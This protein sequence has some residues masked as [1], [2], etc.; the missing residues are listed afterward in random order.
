MGILKSSFLRVT[1]STT[2]LVYQFCTPVAPHSF[3]PKPTIHTANLAI[4]K[5]FKEAIHIGWSMPQTE[6]FAVHS[7]TLLRMFEADS[8]YSVISE[9][10]PS[11]TFN[12]YDNLDPASFPLSSIERNQVYYRIFAIDKSGYPGDTSEPC[13]LHLV[14]QPSFIDIDMSTGCLSWLS[15]IHFG[16]LLSYCKIWKDSL[17]NSIIGSEQHAYPQ[18]DKPAVFTTC[19][20]SDSIDS[21]RWFYALFLRSSDQYSLK[22]GYFN[23]P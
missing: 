10:I 18:T 19:F 5:Q 2:I 9:N 12:F 7:Y 23:V 6:L 17:E 14:Q 21:G 22:V 4:S 15:D 3:L 1:F 8:F 16:G 11:D 13:T 20:S